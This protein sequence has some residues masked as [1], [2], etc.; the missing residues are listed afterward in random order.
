MGIR[1]PSPATGWSGS[2]P[3]VW[4]RRCGCPV[5][6][7][8]AVAPPPRCSNSCASGR[9]AR[10]RLPSATAAFATTWPGSR[11][12]P[13]SCPCG[14]TSSIWSCIA[15]APPVGPTRNAITARWSGCCGKRNWPGCWPGFRPV[16]PRRRRST[17]S[18]CCFSSFT[19]SCRAPRFQ[20]CSSRP[21]PSGAAP[22]A[23]LAPPV[24]GRCSSGWAAPRELGRR[25]PGG[26]PSCSPWPAGP[27]PCGCR[28]VAGASPASTCRSSRQ[29]PG[30]PGCR[31]RAWRE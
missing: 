5:W 14:A 13:R 21:G 3:P 20:R 22:G 11:P 2:A 10:R 28:L 17:G 18:R 25:A 16:N 24:T 29:Q 7:T 9:I 8:T 23:R 27:S 19:T 12:G 31:S 30:A 6:A 4:P 1:W 15:A 26:W